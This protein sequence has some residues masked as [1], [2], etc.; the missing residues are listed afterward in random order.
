MTRRSRQQSRK[1]HLGTQ[2]ISTCLSRTSFV[3]GEEK[4]AAIPGLTRHSIPTFSGDCYVATRSSKSLCRSLDTVFS[5]RVQSL[6]HT[7]RSPKN[8]KSAA[9]F[10]PALLRSIRQG[11]T[12]GTYLAV[13]K[14]L[15]RGW[16]SVQCSPFGAVEKK[17]VDPS[18]EV[19]PIHD[20]SFPDGD[21]TNDHLDPDSV[22][23]LL[24]SSV[25]AIAWRI[26]DISRANPGAVIKIMKGDVKSAF[27]HLMVHAEHVHWMGAT[28]P[29]EGAL[30]IDLAAP[31]GWTGSPAFY[32]AFGRAITWLIGSNSPASVSESTD[33]EPFFGYEWADDHIL[34]EPDRDNRLE[35]AAATLRLSM[36]AVLGPY[37]INGS[38]F[39]D[40]AVEL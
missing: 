27:R 28:I 39:S 21:S 8:H 29:E 19:R 2:L 33:G 25:T 17:G 9:L 32:S 4:P 10:L 11:Q 34:V 18:V 20:L 5:L 23:D 30:V 36:M 1:Q 3:S 40:W 37:S 15:L 24:Y 38:K 7:R 12:G 13:N 16:T 35:L 26:E 14:S 22:P 31:F 6:C